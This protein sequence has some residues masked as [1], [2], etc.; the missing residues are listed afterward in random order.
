MRITFVVGTADMSGGCRVIAI[1]AKELAQ[2][3]H[4]VKV[5]G[6]PHEAASYGQKVR[7]WLEGSGWPTDPPRFPPSHLV[8]DAIDLHIL[9]RR[10]PVI[11]DDVPD[12]DVV[13]ATWWETAEWVNRLAPSKGAKAY[14]VQHHE[15]F[16][17]LP[18]SRCKATYR[19]PL[20]KITIARWLKATMLSEYGD[21][22]VDLVPNSVDRTQFFAPPRAKQAAPTVGFVYDEIE[23]KGVDVALAALKIVKSRLPNLKRV[24]FGHHAPS[25]RLPMPEEV[26]YSKSP[27][28]DHI[29]N[30]Y[31]QC[32]LWVT[33]SR[34]EGFN[35]PAMEAMACRTPIV[36]TRTGWPEEAIETG[37][38][39]VLVDVG[40]VEGLANGIEW[41]ATRSAAE[42]LALSTNAYTTALVGSWT[43]SA[44]QFEAS[45]MHACERAARGEI[46]GGYST[47]AV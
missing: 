27:S 34:T 43:E 11:D 42:W 3:G 9:N 14:F 22:C 4:T 1:Y 35:L 15:V 5:V 29:R 25:T 12:A 31:S 2:M 32:D 24:S 6:P 45:L 21:D 28:Q 37:R 36:A 18:V 30:I 19:L 17:Y 41:I 46:A 26:E 39:G 44:K 7:S 23:F 33:A 16:P 10:R 13:I 40:D 8:D 20:H 47:H 38:N